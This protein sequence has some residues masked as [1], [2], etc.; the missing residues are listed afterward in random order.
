M[1]LPSAGARTVPGGGRARLRPGSLATR[2]DRS[3]ARPPGPG[4]RFTPEMAAAC[5]A[6][7]SPGRCQQRFLA[8]SQLAAAGVGPPLRQPRTH[9]A[10]IS[11][12]PRELPVASTDAAPKWLP[13]PGSPR[14]R[15]GLPPW[16][17]CSALTNHTMV[18]PFSS[19][20]CRVFSHPP[21]K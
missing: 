10:V 4:A 6:L 13:G 5:G 18:A 11:S 8:A 20:G 15:S 14:C 17:T 1:W 3:L 7:A 19:T 9:P 16:V 12:G 2:R 21:K